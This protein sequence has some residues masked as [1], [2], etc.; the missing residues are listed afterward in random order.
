MVDPLAC[1]FMG[2]GFKNT[3]KGF[4]SFMVGDAAPNYVRRYC[5]A[6]S[7]DRWEWFYGQMMAALDLTDEPEYLFYVLKWILKYDFADLAYEMYCQDLLDPECRS[8]SLIKPSKRAEC[9]E[10]YHKRFLQDF[11][12]I[13]GDGDAE[14]HAT[15][16]QPF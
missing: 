6:L 3:L 10:K 16:E 8:E 5:T 1:P 7:D 11:A 13:C 15:Q 4:K 9:G 12:D 2:F 14:C